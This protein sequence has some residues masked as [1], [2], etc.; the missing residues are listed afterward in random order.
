MQ[1]SEFIEKIRTLAKQV[2]ADKTDQP[3]IAKSK[4][5]MVDEFPPLKSIM[6]DLFD[7]QYEPFVN[8]IQWVAPRP[9]TFRVMLV[10]G[11]NFYLIYQGEDGDKK[12]F[13]AQVAGKNYWLESLAEE[14]QA[15]DAIARLLRFNYASVPKD[16]DIEDLF[17]W[18]EENN[19]DGDDLFSIFEVGK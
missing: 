5:P 12:L 17:T 13:T 2:Y 14:Q 6:D 4:F 16:E 3:E 1:K 10:N 15:S 11:A 7:F 9:T 19:G 18:F 8:D